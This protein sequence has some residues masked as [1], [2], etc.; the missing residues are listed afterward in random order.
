MIGPGGSVPRILS[1]SP[2]SNLNKTA[3]LCER[4]APDARAT[5]G[6]R[7]IVG[8]GHVLLWSGGSLWIG[9]DAGRAET[10]AHHAIQ[11]TLAMDSPLRLAAGDGA[12]SEHRGAVVPPHLRHRFDGCGQRTAMLFVEPETAQGRALL[13]RYGVSAITDLPS[14]S[15]EALVAPLRNAWLAGASQDA[16]IALGQDAIAAL[17]GRVPAQAGVD[18]RIA[19]AI[20]WVRSR[21]DVP[22][23]LNEAASVANLS[24]SRFRHLFVA[25]TGVSFRAYLLWARVE[26][27]VG[28]AMSGQS[29][30]AAAQ[31]AGFADSAHL[32]RT[33]RRMFGFA[34]ATLV[35]EPAGE[36]SAAPA[37]PG[38]AG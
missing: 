3:D 7:P 24:P 10:H 13:D 4:A 36:R 2:V 30:T 19:R 23:S 31:D 33:C 37:L 34:P 20:A 25:Q 12:W 11:I 6:R 18:P 8:V 28:A 26:T 17:A 38:R 35:K 16:L 29:W 15:A 1:S 22:I 27:A 9:R 21:L 32:S 14:D 5:G